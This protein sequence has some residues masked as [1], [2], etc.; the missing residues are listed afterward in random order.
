MVD[1]TE[2]PMTEAKMLLNHPNDDF[3]K[4]YSAETIERSQLL[5]VRHA[6]S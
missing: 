3:Y 2:I 4:E 1:A 5:I 6:Y